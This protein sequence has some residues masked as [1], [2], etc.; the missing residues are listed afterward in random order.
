L[1]VL[2]HDIY[3][4]IAAGVIIQGLKSQAS[5]I[6]HHA[7]G[8]YFTTAMKNNHAAFFVYLTVT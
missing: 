1:V 7:A 4:D 8:K 5:G 6:Y 3:R 2:D